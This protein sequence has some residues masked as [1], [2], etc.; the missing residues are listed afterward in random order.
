[1]RRRAFLKQLGLFPFG[2]WQLATARSAKPER[3][4]LMNQF[5]VA[6]FQYYDGPR[7]LPVLKP[8]MRVRLVAQPNHPEDEFAVAIYWKRFQ[9]GYVPRS[10]NKHISR[11]LQS[12]VPVVG[13]ILAVDPTTVPWHQVKVR[14][15]LV[16]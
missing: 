7:V 13:E 5:S 3:T 16:R 1:M 4:V 6:G 14:V 12:G 15:M 11:L 10:D 8:G 2:L 9:L